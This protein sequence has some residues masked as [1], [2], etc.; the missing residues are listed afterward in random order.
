MIWD[1]LKYHK[2]NN[3]QDRRPQWSMPRYVDKDLLS[4]Y[5]SLLLK[6]SS[7]NETKT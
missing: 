3:F 1:Q 7:S 4:L 6:E 2:L 5:L